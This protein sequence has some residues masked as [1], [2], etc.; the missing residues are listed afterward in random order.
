MP[1]PPF[2]PAH[3]KQLL[4][5]MTRPEQVR[6]MSSKKQRLTH[7]L[8]SEGLLDLEPM[9]ETTIL[10]PKG[11]ELIEA[12]VQFTNAKLGGPL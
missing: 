12:L 6:N 4:D 11:K 5:L 7:A 2:S 10:S 1:T 3:L 8:E 9:S